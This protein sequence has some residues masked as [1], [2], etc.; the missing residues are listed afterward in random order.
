MC[1]HGGSRVWLGTE[2]MVGGVN[3]ILFRN[4]LNSAKKVF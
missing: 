2:E 3:D 1:N 4:S